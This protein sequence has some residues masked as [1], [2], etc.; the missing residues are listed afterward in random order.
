MHK[1][2]VLQFWFGDIDNELSPPTQAAM[3]YQGSKALDYAMVEKFGHLYQRAINHELD[4]WLDSPGG[5]LALVILLDQL[6]R[7]MFRGTARAFASDAQAL[8]ISQQGIAA[9]FDCSMAL[10]ERVFYYHPF[11]HSEQLAMQQQCLSL[12]DQLAHSYP[13]EVHQQVIANARHWAQEHLAIIEQ[14][15]RFPHRN[16]ILN[17]A[18]TAAEVQFLRAGVNFGQSAR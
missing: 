11:E 15:G 9:G 1:E 16:Q 10:I 4:D 3:W 17:R 18:S 5:S 13:A 14:F 12:F 8:A 6:P 7:N 2:D